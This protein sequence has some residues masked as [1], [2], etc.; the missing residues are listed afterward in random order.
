[1]SAVKGWNE[2]ELGL[3]NRL[4]KALSKLGFPRPTEVQLKALPFALQGKDLLIRARTGSGKTIAFALPLLNKL[5]SEKEWHHDSNSSGIYSVI[6][7]PTKELCKQIEKVMSDLIYYC[8]DI[9]NVCCLSDDNNEVVQSRL[10]RKPDIIIATPTRVADHCR[11]GALDISAVKML[12]IDE[13]DLVLS[14][15]YTSDL[16]YVTSLLPKILQGIL[17]SATLS[18]R[19]EKLKKVIL[20]NPVVVKV[21]EAEGDNN[22]LQFYLESTDKDKFLILYVFLKLGLLQ[23]YLL[24]TYTI[25]H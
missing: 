21:E 11:S 16:N 18:P 14:F 17:I 20:H 4:L 22:L 5:L 24:Y 12:V 6:M 9:V 3:D 2:L 15:G 19:L 8:R 25:S 23:V 1:M 10:Q 7:A 13:A